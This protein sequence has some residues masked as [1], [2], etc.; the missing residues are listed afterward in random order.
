[1]GKKSR[2]QSAEARVVQSR[3]ELNVF[4][5]SRKYLFT[6][7]LFLLPYSLYSFFSSISYHFCCFSFVFY[8]DLFSFG[9]R[10]F[11]L[12]EHFRTIA[13]GPHGPYYIASIDI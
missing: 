6:L 7:F 2:T 3:N 11:F 8:M 5:K 4:R 12:R 10:P 9:V 13:I 1:M